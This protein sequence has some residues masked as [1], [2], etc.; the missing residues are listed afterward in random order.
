[1]K[2]RILALILSL[3]MIFTVSAVN[4]S[5]MAETT[6][7]SIALEDAEGEIGQDV[8]IK[9]LIDNN[10]GIWGM[11]LRISY[12][13]NVLTLTSVDNG[14]FY[15]DAEWTKGNLNSDVYIL[16]YE[17]SGLDNITIQS[18]TLATLN[19]KVSDTAVAGDYAVT[20]SYNLGDIIN[21][22]F[23]DIDFNITNGKVTIKAKPVSATGVTLNKNTLSLGTGESETL[24]A[25]VSPDNA[26]NKTVKWDSSDTSVATVDSNGKVTALK[27]G[28]AT[29]TVTTEDGSFTDTCA[30]SVTC[31]HTNTTVHPAVASTCQ[32]EGNDEYTTCDDCGVVIS[33]SD[34]KLP[35]TD[36]TYTEKAEAQYLKSAATCKA[37]AVYYKSCSVCGV[38]GSETFEYGNKNP[39]NHTGSTYLKDQKEATCYEEG[40]TGDTYC[41]D[42]NE[43]LK[44]GT[45]IEKSAHNPA[46]VWTTDET[47]HWKECQTIGCGN[48]IEKAPHIGGEATCVV[49]AAC[50]VCGVQYGEVNAS[51]HKHTEVRDAK[52]ATC[53][54]AGYTGD[55]WCTD[56]NTKIANGTVIPATGKHVD[57]D[58][59][60]ETDG[61]NHWHTCYFGTKF[62]V[63]AHSG[64]E[65]TC[66]V[67]AACSVCGVQYGEVNASNH[68]HTEVRD[69]KDATCCEAGY[70]GDTWCTDCNTKIA[71]G[72]VIPA[73][74]KHVDVDGRWET[75]GSNHWHT[76]Y[77][78]TKF[79]VTA[80]SGGEATCVTKAACSVCGTAYG[81]LNASNHKGATYLKDQKEATCYE[82]GYTGDTY[83]SDC[84]AKLKDGTVIEKSA[85]NPASV[86]TTNETHHWKECQTIGC[87]NLIEKAPHIGGEATCTSQA[88]CS[89]C[90]VKYGEKNPAN[91]TGG[92]EIKDALEAKCNAEGYTGDTYCKGCGVKISDGKTIAKTPHVVT[93]WT[94]T[95][96][97]TTESTGTKSGKCNG[98]GETI[99]VTTAKLVSEVKKDNIEGIDAEIKGVG[100]TNL[101]ED[102]I[103]KANNVTETITAPEK[104]K[105]ENS[106]KSS[107]E[108][109]DL[110]IGAIFDLGLILRETS[111]NGDVIAETKLV[112][113]GNVKVT[114]PVPTDLTENLTDLKL[115]HIEDDGTVEIV[116]F[117]L[118]GG[119]ATFETDGF[120][121]YTFVGTEKTTN[122]GTNNQTPSNNE[123]D[124]SPATGDNSKITFWSFVAVI[125]LAVLCTT[126]I[127][128][129][130]KKVR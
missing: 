37:K 66:V 90:G 86:W 98:C 13:K 46:S 93:E 63:T 52:D 12:D 10:P 89:V 128:S 70:T 55:T 94:V 123:T 32:V 103:F 111:D 25:T 77:F 74:G 65:A 14:D 29:I 57:V 45:V 104:T 84:N 51:N 61:T 2:R 6:D 35:T 87:G 72:T 110:K 79:D 49:K 44:D 15:Q 120:S 125:S 130:K 109:A 62:D 71:N 95:K 50:S 31:S 127:V 92:T 23:D 91:H 105:V 81:D 101:S 34:V 26:T 28:T 75:D 30:V 7:P 76:C 73:T 21:V 117:T 4:L 18:G 42:C 107:I 68:K 82:E 54:E 108:F 78:G 85:H 60:W 40:Y 1:M 69:A 41:S 17:A 115:L 9:V 106:I 99:T 122:E 48:L 56:C 119:K 116:P 38:K 59:R 129:K 121:Y 11:D 24:I 118:S 124:K 114:I 64:G 97:A 100:E 16:S 39:E 19:F 43:K 113:T 20:A 53:C 112:L 102:V 3:T 27:K 83:C 22:E 47:H 5:A 80:H 88:I 8:S 58:G 96:E 67:K 36:H 33:G 126:A